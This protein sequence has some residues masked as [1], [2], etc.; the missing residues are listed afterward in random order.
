MDLALNNLQWLICQNNYT[1]PKMSKQAK[2]RRK[3]SVPEK[4]FLWHH[5]GLMLNL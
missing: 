5:N 1:K 3:G 2:I 4:Q